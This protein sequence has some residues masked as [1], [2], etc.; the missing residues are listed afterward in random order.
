MSSILIRNRTRL[1]PIGG[2]VSILP[3]HDRN[4]AH[5]QHAV[6]ILSTRTLGTQLPTAP[7]THA[8]STATSHLRSLI[9]VAYVHVRENAGHVRSHLLHL[10]HPREDPIELVLGSLRLLRRLELHLRLG[11]CQR[12]VD[13]L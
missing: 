8:I 5:Y 1:I 3:V 7:H 2:S 9:I 4:R 11:R 13:A 10:L 6:P 12:G